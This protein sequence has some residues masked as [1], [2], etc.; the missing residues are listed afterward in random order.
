M[1]GFIGLIVPSGLSTGQCCHSPA[2]HAC[3]PSNLPLPPITTTTTPLF[4]I[5]PQCIVF[6]VV[7]FFFLHVA[8]LLGN[9]GRVVNSLDFCSASLKSLGCFYFQCELSSQWKAVTENLLILHCQLKKKKNWRPVIIMCLAI[10]N[11]LLLVL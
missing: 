5:V 4:H 2:D 6:C 1:N 10:S 8:Y 9:S 7:C 3:Q 11:N